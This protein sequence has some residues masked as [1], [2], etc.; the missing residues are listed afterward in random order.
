[1]QKLSPVEASAEYLRHL[2]Q[3]WDT[4]VNAKKNPE[5]ALS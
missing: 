3:A 2:R 5:Q 1:V 4:R